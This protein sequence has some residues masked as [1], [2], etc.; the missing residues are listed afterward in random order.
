MLERMIKMGQLYTIYKF[1]L[2]E[3]QREMLSLYYED[4]FSLSEIADH[5]EITRQG[6]HDNIQRGEKALLEYEEILQLNQNRLK[7]LN[8]YE[9][10]KQVNQNTEVSELIEK[11]VQL[12]D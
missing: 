11:L 8:I 7:R 5:Y 10:I 12:D 6:V 1:L 4:D 3:K 2:T 9:Q